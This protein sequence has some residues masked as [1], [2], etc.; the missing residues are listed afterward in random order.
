MLFILWQRLSYLDQDTRCAAACWLQPLL[1][2]V[3]QFVPSEN[4]L[5][6]LAIAMVPWSQQSLPL[7]FC[8]KHW[9]LLEHEQLDMLSHFVKCVWEVCWDFYSAG[10]SKQKKHTAVSRLLFSLPTNP[11]V[12][13][14]RQGTS[15]WPRCTR[16]RRTSCRAGPSPSTTWPTSSSVAFPPQSG[17]ARRWASRET[18][19]DPEHDPEDP[20]EHATGAIHSWLSCRFTPWP[21]FT[22]TQ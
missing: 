1:A 2:D 18:T 17:T 14:P 6:V 4:R 16:W 7:P 8:H 13:L 15:P 3:S 21:P 9:H 19:R 10:A 12:S 11:G 5:A 20:S 22:S